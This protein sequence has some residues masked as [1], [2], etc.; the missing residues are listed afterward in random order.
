[1]E[2]HREAVISFC[3][4]LSRRNLKYE[5]APEWKCKHDVLVSGKVRCE[6]KTGK[7]RTQ[8]K[9]R[10]SGEYHYTGWYFQLHRHGK[11]NH[12]A[13]DFYCFYL[14][15]SKQWLIVPVSFRKWG[16]QVDLAEPTLDLWLAAFGSRFDLIESFECGDVARGER[17]LAGV[18]RA[19]ERHDEPL[20]V[21]LP[22][23]RGA[24]SLQPSIPEKRTKAVE[25]S[26]ASTGLMFPK[27]KWRKRER[28]G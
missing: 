6:I 21:H 19:V 13:V 5:A 8:T 2:L 11:Q 18:G 14:Y 27:A 12:D 17:A 24:P 22:A 16:P 1:M 28:L 26:L 23:S 4:E 7:R 9:H 3:S 15:E 10:K 25:E 20:K